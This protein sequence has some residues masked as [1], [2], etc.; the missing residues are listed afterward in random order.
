MT[1]P[2]SIAVTLD[3][4]L[5]TL[6]TSAGGDPAASHVAD[7]M[8][9]VPDVTQAKLD[10]ALAAYDPAKVQPASPPDPLDKFKAFLAANPDVAKAI[11]VA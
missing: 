8:L 9:Y 7:G 4:D 2:A 10:K 11:G 6:V 3:H 5:D 1:E